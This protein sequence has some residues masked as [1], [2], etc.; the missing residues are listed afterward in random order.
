MAGIM[1]LAVGVVV[2]NTLKKGLVTRQ[3]RST[4]RTIMKRARRGTMGQRLVSWMD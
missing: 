3:V 2:G 1:G 4:G